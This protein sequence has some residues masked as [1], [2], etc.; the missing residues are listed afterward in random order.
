MYFIGYIGVNRPG[1][2]EGVP[3]AKQEEIMKE[4]ATKSP[5]NWLYIKILNNILRK[6]SAEGGIRTHD[7]RSG[8]GLANLRHTRLGDL[9]FSLGT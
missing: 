6:I 5:S 1:L 7:P 3:T 4:A 8:T 2:M 9:D